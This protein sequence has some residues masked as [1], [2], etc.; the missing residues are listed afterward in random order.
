MKNKLL[1]LAAAALFGATALTAVAQPAPKIFVVDMA[2][3]LDSHHK[4]EEQNAK[5]KGD[6]QKAREQIE[7]LNSEGNA[8]V[9]EYKATVEKAKNPA[10]SNDAKTKAEAE[11][12]GKLE[13]IQKKQNQVQ[14]F[15]QQTQRAF[16]QRIKSFRDLMLEEIGKIATDI[17][18]KKGATILLDKSGPSLIGISN[19]IYFDPSYDITEEVLKE[20]NKGRPAGSTAAAAG[21]PAPAAESKSDD[22]PLF[23]MPK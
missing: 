17:A 14:S 22:K 12:Q 2:K 10:L 19:L 23:E 7:Q 8:L 5:L 9:E 11:A 21:K 3:L 6:E 20:I 13:E 1:S 4:T 18:K 16:Q 15:Q